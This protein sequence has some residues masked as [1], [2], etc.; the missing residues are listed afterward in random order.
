M[1]KPHRKI[2]RQK[3]RT[4]KHG[5]QN[6]YAKVL[7]AKLNKLNKLKAKLYGGD[8]VPPSGSEELSSGNT[9]PPS[10]N[11][12]PPSE[13]NPDAE[14]HNILDDQK[15]H[16]KAVWKNTIIILSFLIK[17]ID[18]GNI[19]F[20]KDTNNIELWEET[21]N[22]IK[23]SGTGLWKNP[24]TIEDVESNIELMQGQ[25]LKLLKIIIGEEAAAVAAATE[26]AAAEEAAQI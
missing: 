9:E 18:E 1:K 2:S 12:E 5:R 26:A 7:K 25:T 20:A 3:R 24:H 21:I 6:K 22:M 8:K 23:Y 15:K 16:T 4:Q 14:T 10:G 19:K 17:A 13:R 11:T